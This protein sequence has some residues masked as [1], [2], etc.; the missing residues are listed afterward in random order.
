MLGLIKYMKQD[1]FIIIKNIKRLIIDIDSIIS[2]FPNKEKVLRDNI[3]KTAYEIL[4]LCYES[5]A[6]PLKFF[7]KERL[8]LEYKVLSLIS[9]L[10]FYLEESYILGYVSE[11]NTKRKSKE[12]LNIYNKVKGLMKTEESSYQGF[13]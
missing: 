3:K 10:D 1:N 8:I 12:L 11:N 9:I 2:L 6:L 13:V 4:K 5:N 7:Y